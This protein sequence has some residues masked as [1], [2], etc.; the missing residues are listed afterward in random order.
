MRDKKA[1]RRVSVLLNAQTV[2]HLERMAAG[3]GYKNIGRVIDKLVREKMLSLRGY[4]SGSETCV[5]C[6][7]P[8]PEGRMICPLCAKEVK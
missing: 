5:C 2:Y 1:Q 8:I 7:R 3:A 4:S 6:G